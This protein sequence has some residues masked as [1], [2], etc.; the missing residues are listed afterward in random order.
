MVRGAISDIGKVRDKNQDAYYVSS[1]NDLGLYI[2]AD[3]MGGHKS[4]EIAS[5]MALETVKN[6]FL[7]FDAKTDNKADILKLIKASIEEANIKIYLKSLETLEC[8]GMGTTMTLAYIFKDNILLGHVGDSRAYI[9]KDGNM[10]QITEDH[11]YINELLKNG[12]ITEEEA[13]THPKK[14]MITRAIGTS[15]KIE[16]DIIEEKYKLGDIL[17][18]CSD[19]LYNMLEEKE[20]NSV[21]NRDKSMQESCE[22]LAAMA[23]EKGGLDNIT[24]VAI[25]FD[26]VKL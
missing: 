25:K 1:K 15:S 3:G 14:N 20:I 4:G 5:L 18:I 2:V 7:K 8:Q 21:F 11:S 12:T 9:I 10:I 26:E 16:V 24:V 22:I 19:G 23:N 6:Q 13:K 17:L